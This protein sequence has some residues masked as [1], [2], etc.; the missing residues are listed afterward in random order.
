MIKMKDITKTYV[1]GKMNLEVLRGI[2]LQVNSGEM[3]AIMGPS[4]S[5]KSTL[6][7]IIGCLDQ[8]T[9]GTYELDDANIGKLSDTKLARIRNKKIGFVFQHYNLLARTSALANV[10]VPLIYG[11]EK[12]RKKRALEVLARVGL[13]DRVKHKPNE[14][15]GGQQ[16]RVSIARAM[17]NNPSIILADEPTGNLDTRTG[18]EIMNL[19]E[20][21]NRNEGITIVLVTHEREIAERAQRIIQIRDG[22]IIDEEVVSR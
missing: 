17:I 8:Q 6:M 13:A 18:K 5:G 7:N 21:L 22:E 1:I 11:R 9:S 15:S 12:N 16:Q 14:L 3:L 19:F 10:E 4:G 2:N 20:A